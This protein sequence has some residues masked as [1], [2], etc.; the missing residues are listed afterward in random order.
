MLKTPAIFGPAIENLVWTPAQI[1][2]KLSPHLRLHQIPQNPS[3]E[4]ADL[5]VK[6][7]EESLVQAT[8]RSR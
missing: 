3:P 8:T 7:K 2:G 4:M 1:S 5:D 6:L